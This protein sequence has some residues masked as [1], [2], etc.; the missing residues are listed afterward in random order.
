M[1]VL[2]FLV[3]P[4]VPTMVISHRICHKGD[5]TSLPP[6]P[7]RFHSV[8]DFDEPGDVRTTQQARQYVITIFFAR[9]L[10][11][12]FQADVV[13]VR[14][15]FLELVV[16][17]RW[18]PAESLTVLG[19]FKSRNRNSTGVG[20]LSGSVPKTFATPLARCFKDVNGLFG[21]TLPKGR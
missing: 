4:V 2:C 19:H 8:R 17:F 10:A 13:A 15:D 11:S 3:F 7:L 5:A 21:A 1:R 12:S 18:R 6:V 16:D 9:P 14:H 20:G